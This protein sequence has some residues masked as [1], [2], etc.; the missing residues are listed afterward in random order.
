MITICAA[1]FQLAGCSYSD[2][3]APLQV[4][5]RQ[6]DGQLLEELI[7]AVGDRNSKGGM[8][9]SL[10]LTNQHSM[11]A[12]RIWNPNPRRMQMPEDEPTPDHSLMQ[13]A[14]KDPIFPYSSAGQGF[15]QN[16]S[17]YTQF[18]MRGRHA[19]PFSLTGGIFASK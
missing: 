8:Q 18:R 4:A 2:N 19:Q 13:L 12:I 16:S 15:L 1:I 6:I 3:A 7:N 17:A 14:K 10:P 9:N 11:L 5:G